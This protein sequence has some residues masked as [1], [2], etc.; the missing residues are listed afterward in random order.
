M[1]FACLWLKYKTM[2]CEKAERPRT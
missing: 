1:S 2:L